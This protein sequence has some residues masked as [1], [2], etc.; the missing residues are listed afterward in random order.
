MKIQL[1]YKTG[2]SKIIDFEPNKSSIGTRNPDTDERFISAMVPKEVAEAHPEYIVR[3]VSSCD[4]SVKG[5]DIVEY[6]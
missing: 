2:K 1:R 6:I 4:E 5:Q 3:L